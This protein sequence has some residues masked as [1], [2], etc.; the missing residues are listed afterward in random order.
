MQID[1]V[2]HEEDSIR[3]TIACKHT[4]ACV[5]RLKRHIELFD[6]RIRGKSDKETV[7]VEL[8]D[9]LYFE[10]VDNHSFVYTSDKVI[11]IEQKLYELEQFLSQQKIFVR[12]SKSQIINMNKIIRLKPELNRTIQATMCN[13]ERLY[14][15]RRY[16]RELKKRLG[17]IG[18]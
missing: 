17:I 11:E 5:Y 16:V 3:V 13:G 7:F 15:S 14:I 6:E 12:S 1:I 8:S 2:N 18:G 4:D 9:V 10:V